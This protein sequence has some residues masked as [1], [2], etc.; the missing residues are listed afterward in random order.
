M[1]SSRRK[2][3]PVSTTT[4]MRVR[5]RQTGYGRLSSSAGAFRTSCQQEPAPQTSS[6]WGCRSGPGCRA[7]C[8]PIH[9]LLVNGKMICQSL[10]GR[11]N[12]ECT[13]DSPRELVTKIDRQHGLD[14]AL[15]KLVGDC[16]VYQQSGRGQKQ[17]L[18]QGI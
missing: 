5:S 9:Q 10:R 17:S 13:G 1:T 7:A 18:P 6:E 3:A 2:G 16:W 12:L 8:F 4:V 11:L 14:I 15:C